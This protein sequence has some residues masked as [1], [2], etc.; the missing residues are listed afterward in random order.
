MLN[1]L[2][3]LQDL[4]TH[5]MHKIISDLHNVRNITK[6]VSSILYLFNL[7]I[8]L[9][10]YFGDINLARD[11]FLHQ[12]IKEDDGCIL[13]LKLLVISILVLGLN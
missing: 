9:Q 12:Q 11:K 3:I 13:W 10:Y 5:I 2:R 7:C 8:H 6:E 4:V 1:V